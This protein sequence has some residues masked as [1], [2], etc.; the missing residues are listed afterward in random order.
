VKPR[1]SACARRQ[2]AALEGEAAQQDVGLDDALD[3][4][5]GLPPFHVGDASGGMG[6]DLGVAG[7]RDGHGELERPSLEEIEA[8]GR[9]RALD[10]EFLRDGVADSGTQETHRRGGD[11]RRVDEDDVGVEGQ[12]EDL[13]DRVAVVVDDDHPA[14]RRVVGGDGRRDEERQLAAERHALGGVDRLAAA[15]RDDDVATGR[16]AGSGEPGDLAMRAIAGEVGERRG[17]AEPRLEA[18]PQQI[19]RHAIRDD[20]RAVAELA[21]EPADAVKC[22]RALNIAARRAED[23]QLLCHAPPPLYCGGGGTAEEW[24]STIIQLPPSFT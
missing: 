8:A 14:G 13:G 24:W 16:A 1:V 22:V 4:R 18:R 3:R 21:G 7:L 10:L 5:A 2:P 11:H 19:E 6:A 17:G 15:E 23:C 20:E 9:H 12:A